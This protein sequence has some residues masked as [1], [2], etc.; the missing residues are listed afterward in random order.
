MKLTFSEKCDILQAFK[1]FVVAFINALCMVKHTTSDEHIFPFC[2]LYGQR[3]F[4]HWDR[5]NTFSNYHFK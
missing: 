1:P 2:C 3:A 4:S 5:T